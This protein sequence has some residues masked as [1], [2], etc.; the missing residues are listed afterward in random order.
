MF[1]IDAHLDLSM[2]AI[3]WDR[4]LELDVYEIRRRE[5]HMTEK[6]RARGTVTLARNAQS[7]DR[8]VRGHGD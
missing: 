8:R 1:L 5:A 3:N 6:G 4:D 7:R 2:N